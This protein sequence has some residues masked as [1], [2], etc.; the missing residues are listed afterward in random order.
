MQFSNDPAV[1]TAKCVECQYCGEWNAILQHTSKDKQ[2]YMLCQA[3]N[4]PTRNPISESE[5]KKT[6]PCISFKKKLI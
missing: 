6:E 3:P 4:P 5:A 1:L 2:R